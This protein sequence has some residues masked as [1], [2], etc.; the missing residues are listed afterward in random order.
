[1]LDDDAEDLAAVFRSRL[2]EKQPSNLA[3]LKQ[4]LRSGSGG[5]AT[6][7]LMVE[8][9]K[10]DAAVRMLTFTPEPTPLMVATIT[11]YRP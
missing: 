8:G 4:Q 5:D 7:G 10:I 6:R 1:L 2:P 11:Y 9:E 3:A